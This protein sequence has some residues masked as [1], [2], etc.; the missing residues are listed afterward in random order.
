MSGGDAVAIEAPRL[1]GSVLF[2]GGSGLVGRSAARWF[3]KRHPDVRLLIGGR[4]IEAAEAVARDLRSAKAVAIDLD[5]PWFG[6]DPGVSLAAIAVLAPEPG[7]MGLRTAT[8]L[9]VPYLN[10][11]VGLTEVGPEVAMAS[12]REGRSA[13]A[14]V[15]HWMGGA[16]THLALASARVFDR[17]DTVRMGTVLDEEDPAGPAALEDMQRVQKDAPGNMAF[18]AGRRVLLSGDDA[19]GSVVA[20]DGR[21]LE[22]H[23]FSSFDI[24]SVHAATGAANVRFDIASGPS[25]SRRAGGPVAIEIVVEIEGEASGRSMRTRSTLEFGSG[26][27]SLTGL[28]VALGL[29]RLVGLED[30]PAVPPGLYLPERLVGTDWYFQQVRGAG[31]AI[32]IGTG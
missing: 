15:S 12:Q 17:V 26:Q 8:A 5:E 20:V 2:V 22:A 24:A 7:T 18:C 11:G 23:A 19:K 29:A 1:G 28:S 21:S 32:R 25:S 31:A 6:I 14:L 4:R 10:I 16:A 30:G 13:I 27:A 9:G 3:N